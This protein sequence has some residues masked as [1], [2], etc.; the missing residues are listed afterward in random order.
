MRFSM[1]LLTLSPPPNPIPAPLP[2]AGAI[3]C[4]LP[5]LQ[6]SPG[7][8]DSLPVPPEQRS[9]AVSDAPG[10]GRRGR[11]R[12]KQGKNTARDPSAGRDGEKGSRRAPGPVPPPAPLTFKRGNGAGSLR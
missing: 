5:S 10:S 2:A 9:Q 6:A 12:S 8:R 3:P 4:L 1:S 7:M 11:E